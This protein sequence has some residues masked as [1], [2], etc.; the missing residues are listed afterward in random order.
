MTLQHA[1]HTQYCIIIMLNKIH[2]RFFLT[3][4][5]LGWV[6]IAGAVAAIAGENASGSI[7]TSAEKKVTFFTGYG[8][9]VDGNWE[10]P[11]RL[12]VSEKPDKLRRFKARGVRN[13]LQSQAALGVLTDKQK[14]TYLERAQDFIADSESRET[15][16]IEFANDPSAEKFVLRGSHGIKKTDRNGNLQGA[17]SLTKK[18]ANELLAAQGNSGNWLTF[19]AVSDKHYGTGRIRLVPPTGISIISDIDDTVKDTGITLGHDVVLRNTFFEPFKQVP[20][21]AKFYA[22]FGAD[23]SFH[24]VSG[25]PW[26]LYSPLE[27]FL[28]NGQSRFPSGSMHMKNV[29]TNLTER[30]SYRDF[31]KLFK[32]GSKQTTYGQK[33]SQISRIITDFPNRQFVLIG[34]SGERD[35]EVFNTIRARFPNNVQRIIIRDVNDQSVDNA[36]RFEN[37]EI[38]SG[39]AG[40]QA[41]CS[42]MSLRLP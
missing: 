31:W 33:I 39:D 13:I 6:L 41:G 40:E 16:A 23:A 11:F 7:P 5:F 15:V 8:Y 3:H 17:F 27:S 24:Y 21:M 19:H 35:P 37:I 18:R 20:C 38:I 22:S 32:N 4:A 36:K 26:Q 29:R 30:A 25:A 28:F 9:Q 12:W 14:T 34:D 42:E 1:Q 10:I 2:I